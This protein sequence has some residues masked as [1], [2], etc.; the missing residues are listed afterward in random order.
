MVIYTEVSLGKTIIGKN[1]RIDVFL[2]RE[3]HQRALAIECKFQNVSGTADEKIPYALQ[4]LEALWIQSLCNRS[5]QLAGDDVA[6]CHPR[7]ARSRCPRPLRSRSSPR[8]HSG[9]SRPRE[10]TRRSRLPPF[11]RGG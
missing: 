6:R 8:R 5:W 9:F 7:S 2:L 10:G 3:A 11:R 4:D 1:R